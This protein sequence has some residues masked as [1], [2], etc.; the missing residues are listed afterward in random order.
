[1]SE[2]SAPTA[3]TI[4]RIHPIVCRLK[5]F[6][7]TSTAQMRIAPAAIRIMLTPIP[8]SAPLRFCRE[9][10]GAAR[11][12][13]R[14]GRLQERRSF[15][16]RLTPDRALE[17]LDEAAGF[18]E[19]R[20]MLT[21]TPDSSLPSL[22]EACHEESYA[23]DKPGFGQWPRTKWSWSFVLAGRPGVYALKIHSGK[24]LYVSE[25]TARILDPIC[26]AEIRRME[27]NPDWALLLRHLG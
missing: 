26:R 5:P 17:T 15:L 22:F 20:G 27:E 13:T 23:P 8:I 12:D 2:S 24:T 11:S 6:V 16:C 3:P 25:E 19:E 9:N 4:S 21:R 14:L 7:V 18:L 1:M 10:V